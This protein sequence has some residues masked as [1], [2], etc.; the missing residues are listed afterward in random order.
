MLN[1]RLGLFTAATQ[2]SERIALHLKWH[3]FS[4]SYEVILQSSLT[5][6]L[7]F[8]LVFSTRLPVSVCGT[9]APVLPR[10]F[11]RQ[12][13]FTRLGFG[14]PHPRSHLS[15]SGK[16]FLLSFIDLPASMCRSTLR[17]SPCVTPSVQTVWSGTG[18][19]TSCPSGAA[20]ALPLG[21]T[22]PK[23]INLASET[24][25]FRCACF[26]QAMRYSYR[27]SLL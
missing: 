14:K 19:S 8:T 25:D 7:S 5:K 23:W 21:P 10:G 20:F 12:F 4:R 16:A 6:G 26:S 11:S 3:L 17:L 1:S 27:H 22:N 24:L 18:L 13:R 9:G 15:V 2:S